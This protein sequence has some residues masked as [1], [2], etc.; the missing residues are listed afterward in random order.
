MK[1]VINGKSP[2]K[3]E[4]VKRVFSQRFAIKDLEIYPVPL[5]NHEDRYFYKNYKEMIEE[6]LKGS[7]KLMQFAPSNVFPDWAIYITE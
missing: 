7:E 3:I 1:V 6:A 4:A 2:T 5:P